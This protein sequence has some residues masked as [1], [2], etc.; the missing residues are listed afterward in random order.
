VH[1]NIQLTAIQQGV[2]TSGYLLLGENNKTQGGGSIPDLY[3]N[4]G[5]FSLLHLNGS[6][7][8]IPGGGFTQEYGYRPWMKTGITFTGNNDLMYFGVRSL[9]AGSDQSERL[10][11]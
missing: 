8:S 3:Q 10:A 9:Q 6:Q 5:A 1:R 2:N 11:G 7:S 4:K